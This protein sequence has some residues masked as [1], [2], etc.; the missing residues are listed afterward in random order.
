VV[1]RDPQAG[2]MDYYVYTTDDNGG[3]HLNSGIPNRA[4]TLAAT[5]LGTPAWQTAASIW[6]A[7]L[8]SG[9]RPDTGFTTFAQATLDAARAVSSAAGA[10]VESAWA[11]VGVCP[12]SPGREGTQPEAETRGAS[13]VAVRRSGGLGGITRSAEVRLGDDP[14]TPE[15]E[16]LLTHIDPERVASTPAAPDR[17]VYSFWLS[18]RQLTVGEQALTPEL[19]RLA[20][21]ILDD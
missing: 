16:D 3:V 6:Y 5:R 18:G 14:R 20:Q 2:H 11:E 17:F 1:G 8:T 15:V 4:F 21:L 12:G 19:S 10:A 7:A 13:I 9:L